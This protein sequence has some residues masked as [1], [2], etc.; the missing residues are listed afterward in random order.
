[1]IIVVIPCEGL[2]IAIVDT[3]SRVIAPFCDCYRNGLNGNRGEAS[4]QIIHFPQL[5]FPGSGPPAPLLVSGLIQSQKLPSSGLSPLPCFAH[6]LHFV[7][8]ITVQCELLQSDHALEH[9][10]STR[11]RIHI[12]CLR[13][14][15]YVYLRGKK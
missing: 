8:L 4:R 1:L 14:G 2:V 12:Q 13:T 10:C 6:A 15:E 11:N 5:M 7:H 9:Y 3:P